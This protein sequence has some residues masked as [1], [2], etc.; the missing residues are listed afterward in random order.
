[1]ARWALQWFL[2]QCTHQMLSRMRMSPMTQ[3][4][5]ELVNFWTARPQCYFTSILT[6]RLKR[7]HVLSL[8]GPEQSIFVSSKVQC[9]LASVTSKIILLTSRELYLYAVPTVTGRNSDLLFASSFLISQQG[10]TVWFEVSAHCAVIKWGVGAV[11]FPALS[12][13]TAPSDSQP[14][15]HLCSISAPPA[16][17]V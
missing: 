1:M 15:Q 17:A 10:F 5:F 9:L 6:S 13:I 14:L 16:C 11:C 7:E 2:I 12:C 4:R 8:T 3:D